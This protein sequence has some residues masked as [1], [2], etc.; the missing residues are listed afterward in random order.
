MKNALFE[1]KNPFEVSGKIVLITGAGSGLG[2]GYSHIFAE[3]G[4]AVCCADINEETAK[5]TA[6]G[7]IEDGGK[8]Y[9]YKVDTGEVESIKAMVEKVIKDQGRIDVLINNAGT[10]K[11][12]PAIEYDQGTFDFI[13]N[14][15]FRGTFFVATE[16]AKRMIQAGNGG[17]I[18]NIASINAF[19][20]MVD[21][22]I[23]AATKAA[24]LLHTKTMALEW[25]QHNI[26]VNAILPGFCHTPMAD[27][28]IHS[29]EDLQDILKLIPMGRGGTPKDLAGPIIMLSSSASDY[30]TGMSIV[31]DGGWTAGY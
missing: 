26:Q 24:V 20:G 8:A 1:N 7:I 13:S 31:V 4:A 23:Y 27:L 18:V 30:M 25:I 28:F 6:D 14:V 10:D 2:K 19:L 21:S 11:C 16:V 12:M 15:N 5:A 22:A 29:E 9:A 3:L 17:K